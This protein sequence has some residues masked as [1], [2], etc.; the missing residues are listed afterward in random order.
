M[1]DIL[2]PVLEVWRS[3]RT[4]AVA[5]VVDTSG[6]APRRAG[7]AM[8]ITADGE[9]VGSVSGGCIDGVVYDLGLEA[10]GGAPPRLCRFDSDGRDIFAVG[11]TC[12]GD[13]EIFIEPV[14]NRTFSGLESVADDVRE[15]RP[16]AVAKII[17]HADP[18]QL[19]R[20]IIVRPDS[21]T[22]S[23]GD[24]YELVEDARALLGT[25]ES[26]TL[27]NEGTRVFVASYQ[28]RPR[29]IVFGAIDFAAAIARQGSLLGFHVTVCDARAVF[30]THARFPGVDEL[31]VSWPAKYLQAEVDAGR[32]DNRTAICVLTHDP[33]FDVPLLE[34]ALTLPDDDAPAFIGA[35]GSSK[36]HADRV[37]RLEVAGVKPEHLAQLSSPI[38]L[39]L[40]GH[41]PEE[42]AL[43]VMA[44]IIALRHGGTGHRLTGSNRPIH[45]PT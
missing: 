6:S 37:T 26:A 45:R 9:V 29:L 31:V 21:V 36:T 19:G 25:G 22:G 7:A 8:M 13:L 24:L 34:I 44:E 23:V 4:A 42:T 20:R 41:T 2:G 11:L 10:L 3:G 28:P 1:R 17:T 12:G 30:A 15:G 43:S 33:K 35:M 27:S 40:G 18:R 5:T 14:S 38:G 32:V 16:V 39:D